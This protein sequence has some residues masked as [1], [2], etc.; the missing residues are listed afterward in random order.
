M[1]EMEGSVYLVGKKIGY[2]EALIR[3]VKIDNTI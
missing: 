2:I 3:V 1:A